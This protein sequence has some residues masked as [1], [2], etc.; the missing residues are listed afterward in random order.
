LFFDKLLIV[1]YFG[2]I[3]NRLALGLDSEFFTRKHAH[4][5]RLAFS[6][7]TAAFPDAGAGLSL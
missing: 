5:P 1:C 2:N 4:P 6:D 7:F 3:G